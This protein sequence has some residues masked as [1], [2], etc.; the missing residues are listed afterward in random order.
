MKIKKVRA[1]FFSATG[2][3]EKITTAIAAR[4]AAN[5][6]IPFEIT[7]FSLP[8]GRVEPLRFH[9]GE[10]IIFGIFVAAGRVPNLLLPYLNT[11]IS[12]G[13]FAVPV[14]LYGNRHYDD[15]LIELRDILEASGARTIAAGA[16]IGQHSFSDTLAKGRPDRSDILAAEA[17][18]ERLA[19]KIKVN[20]YGNS[21][22][23]VPGVPYPYRGYY[24]PL[25][26]TG[27]P[28]QFLKAKPVTAN[29][30]TDCK[31][32]ADI[33]PMGAIKRENVKEVPGPC[34]KCCV[35]IKKCPVGAKS[36]QDENFLS[37][38]ALL[39]KTY[40]KRTDPEIFI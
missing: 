1:V 8:K 33:C 31:I 10:L 28:V 32:C 7:N 5:L 35:C 13:A 40:K 17:F 2:T 19:E 16:F 37:H 3:T 30:C 36:F 6:D 9:T 21:P 20:S 18:A 22:I 38:R 23:A 27:L 12:K 4:I 24:Q 11:I 34:I 14:V 39:E 26:E 25:D 29:H 15:A